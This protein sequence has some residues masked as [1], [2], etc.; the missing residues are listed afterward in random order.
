VWLED[1]MMAVDSAVKSVLR[2]AVDT[3]VDAGATVDE[4]RPSIDVEHALR[5]YFFLLGAAM[6]SGDPS[7]VDAGRAMKDA[8]V[9]PGEPV[10]VSFLRGAAADL[11]EWNAARVAQASVRNEWARFHERYDVVLCPVVATAALPTEPGVPF[12]QRT[13]V[14]DGEVR[15]VAE[16]MLWCAIIGAAYL[17]ATVVPAGATPDGLPVGVQIVGAYYD[18][19]TA[20]DAARRIDSVLNAYRVP[21][22]AAS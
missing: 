18:D 8:A 17:P 14:L 10:N 22:L 19:L 16:N 4:A 15:P 20:L 6:G 11:V 2:R 12:V 1:P 21:P 13:M 7:A 5:T 9:A 3:L